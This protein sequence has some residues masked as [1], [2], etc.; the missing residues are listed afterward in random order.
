MASA[1]VRACEVLLFDLGGVIVELS[2]VPQWAARAGSRESER[3]VWERW[4][5]SPTVRE[6]ECGRCA[7]E[8]FSR[9]MVAEFELRVDSAEFL[10]SFM[11]W[12]LGLYPGALALLRQLRARSY[13]LACFS[14]TNPVHWP[15]FLDEMDLRGHF[16]ATFAS[17]E[18]GIVKPDVEAFREVAHRLDCEPERILLL[19]DNQ[20]NVEGARRAGLRAVRVS[21]VDGA[22][23][24]LRRSGLLTDDT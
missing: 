21:G 6:F 3:L 23:R 10:E 20:L 15:R 14:N 24:Y 1:P 8:D 22:E 12:P 13:R 17:F 9:R 19:D 16:D 11:A 7:P 4:L 2:G 18:L 5:R